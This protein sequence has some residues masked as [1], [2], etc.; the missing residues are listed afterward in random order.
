MKSKLPLAVIALAAVVATT[1]G[2]AFAGVTYSTEPDAAVFPADL[3]VAVLSTSVTPQTED[4]VNQFVSAG[5]TLAQT[6]T[7]GATGFTLDKLAIYSGGKAGGTVRISL[8][9]IPSFG[10]GKNTDGFVNSSFSTDLLGGG[11]GAQATVFGSGGAQY[12][13]FDLTG[14]DEVTLAPNQLYDLEVDVITGSFGWLRSGA[15]GYAGGN[16]YQGATE[17]NFNGT[18]PANSRGERDAV[19]GSPDRDGGLAL[20]AVASAPLPEPSALALAL[21]AA[22]MTLRRRR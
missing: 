5:T 14:T 12:S 18:A 13:I 9:A 15:A 6:F 22:A 20:Y 7:T 19:G 4:T 16:I 3:G 2:S 8:Y 11:N 1:A 21:P 10:G 17:L